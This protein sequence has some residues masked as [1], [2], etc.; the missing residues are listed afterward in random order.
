MC[1]TEMFDI[2]VVRSSDTD[3]LVILLTHSHV[4]HPQLWLDVGVSTNN[5]RRYI[6]VSKLGE[7][8]GQCAK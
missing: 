3:V 5:S 8:M 4:I 2:I 1:D 6:H 7:K